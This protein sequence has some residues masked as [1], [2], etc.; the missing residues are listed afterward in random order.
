M[1][2][3][4]LAW[5]IRYN[6]P[7]TMAPAS[8]T[9]AAAISRGWRY[10]FVSSP[11]FSPAKPTVW[12]TAQDTDCAAD[13]VTPVRKFQASLPAERTVCLICSII[14]LLTS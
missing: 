3:S 1:L 13:I 14:S 6:V 9:M 11:S 10:F 8:E 7:V 12:L 2:E 5:T 4:D